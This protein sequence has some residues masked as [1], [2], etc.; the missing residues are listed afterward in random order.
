MKR[1]VSLFLTGGTLYPLL[2]ILWRGQTHPSMS[3]TGGACL[4]LIDKVCNRRMENQS[5][6]RRCL[7][8]SGIITGVEFGVGLLVNVIG[9]RKVWDYSHVPFN[10]F[11]Q[12]C[13]PYTILWY[14]LTIPA[15]QL[16]RL[17][18]TA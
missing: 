15:M 11:G 3:V 8:G 2:E 7:A 9:K 14:F 16:C 6:S 17:S 10:L 18:R 1:E 4:C 12:V 13:L 5:L